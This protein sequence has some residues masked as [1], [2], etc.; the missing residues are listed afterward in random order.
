MFKRTWMA[1]ALVALAACTAA[2][3]YNVQDQPITTASG[4]APSSPDVRTAILQAGAA[5]GWQMRD[6]KPCLMEGELHLRTH[7]AVVDIPYNS[8]SYS[9]VYKSS[10][11]LDESGGNIHKNYNGW[12]HNLQQGINARLSALR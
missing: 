5:L 3:I 1:A 2:P 8:K 12:I 7:S 9:I 4:T 6:V 11:N 10:T